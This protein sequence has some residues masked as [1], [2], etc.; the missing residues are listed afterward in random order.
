M[1]IECFQASKQLTKITPI[2]KYEFCTL[3]EPTKQNLPIYKLTS[4][5]GRENVQKIIIRVHKPA[6]IFK[7]Y[8]YSLIQK[9]VS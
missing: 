9:N 3:P 8:E 6:G 7:I 4:I 1:M 2:M 5:I